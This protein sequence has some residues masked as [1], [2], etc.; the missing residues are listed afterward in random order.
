M[1]SSLELYLVRHAVAA[2][3][4]AAWP[5]DGQRP[6]TPRGTHRFTQRVNG[7][8]ALGLELDEVFTSPLVRARQTAQLLAAGVGGYPKVKLLP[9]LSPGHAP[10]AVVAQLAKVAAGRSIA[11]VG[12]ESGLGEL[13]GFLIGAGRA[14]PF[15]KGGVCRIDIENLTRRHPGTLI[16]F[17]TPKVLRAL[18]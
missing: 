6:L 5:D 9:G 12:H 3:R 7:L 2:E 18:A 14:L 8:A 13:A 15:K 10:A 11:L 4:G 1:P 17:V 16:W